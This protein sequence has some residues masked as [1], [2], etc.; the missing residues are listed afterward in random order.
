MNLN[1]PSAWL[2]WFL[3][4]KEMS[5]P[6]GRA[7]FRYRTSKFEFGLLQKILDTN[8]NDAESWNACFV[9]YASEC[10]RRNYTE[11]HWSWDFIVGSLSSSNSVNLESVTHRSKV[12]ESGVKYWKR[13]VYKNANG[14]NGYLS[15]IILECG[16]PEGILTRSS[17]WLTQVIVDAYEEL[18]AISISELEPQEVVRHIAEQKDQFPDSLKKEEIYE[19]VAQITLEAINLKHSY[20]LENKQSPTS[21]LDAED[22]NWRVAFPIEIS[23]VAA[24]FLD[25]LLT[26][27]AKLPEPRKYSISLE[28]ELVQTNLKW[29]VKA[30]LRFPDNFYDYEDL[31][32]TEQELV[33]PVSNVDIELGSAGETKKI[34]TAFKTQKNGKEGFFIK[35]IANFQLGENACLHSWA[36]RLS[37][38]EHDVSI[39]LPLPGGEAL[40][41]DLPWVFEEKG[42]RKLF[43][44]TGSVSSKSD[45]IY[46][47]AEKA[48]VKNGNYQ[49]V[50]S[51]NEKK[52][53]Y[54][55]T[56]DCS[57]TVDDQV[58]LYETSTESDTGYFYTLQG[59]KIDYVSSQ[60]EIVYA[61]MPT[62]YRVDSDNLSKAP[63][64]KGIHVRRSGENR[65]H[66]DGRDKVGVLFIRVLGEKSEVLF[67]KKINVL[68]ANFSVSIE[69]TSPVQGKINLENSSFFAIGI[70]EDELVG[71]IENHQFGHSVWIKSKEEVPP[72]NIVISLG[73]G[74]GNRLTIEVPFPS[75]GAK[76]FDKG[77]N[78]MA[79]GQK[80]YL[81]DLFGYSLSLF[82]AASTWKV[83]NLI[84]SLT[85]KESSGIRI[86]R[87]IKVD[88][89]HREVPLIRYRDEFLK[90]FS[91]TEI[92]DAEVRVRVEH[93]P[94]VTIK[95]YSTSLKL[96]SYEG[97]AT[98]SGSFQNLS[99]TKIS[100]FRFDE[101]LKSQE[102]CMLDLISMDENEGTWSFLEEDRKP[103]KW[104]L[105]PNAESTIQFRPTL[106]IIGY[107]TEEQP[108]ISGI[109]HI[110]EAAGIRNA[111][112][113]IDAL[114]DLAQRMSQDLGNPNWQEVSQLWKL[115]NHLPLNTFD[116]WT[117]FSRNHE[118]LVSLFFFQE[119]ELINRLSNEYPIL[120]E[121]VSVK[122][123]IDGATSRYEH[124]NEQIP[125]H[126]DTLLDG[127]FQY[128]EGRLELTCIAAILRS[129]ILGFEAPDL[130]A[131][132][133]PNF[134][135]HEFN[136]LLNG[137]A[138]FQGLKNRKAEKGWQWPEYLSQE[139]R[140]MTGKLP[141][142]LKTLFPSEFISH[143]VSVILLPVVLAVSTINKELSLRNEGNYAQLFQLRE[144]QSFDEEWFRA[145]Y[146][147]IQGYYWVNHKFIKT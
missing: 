71:E 32:L 108:C 94:S 143:R 29:I 103:G 106:W 80:L 1:T 11:G 113:R 134:I 78:V 110:R 10:W 41:D 107:E 66:Q 127:K 115:T 67:S 18:R 64:T 118:A 76:F 45:T 65:W 7:L 125:E 138:G 21:F 30:T 146:N 44:G 109:T 139:I 87:K 74:G 100:A 69:S 142:E 82:N 121:T 90:L 2:S 119:N 4:R 31:H 20:Q 79:E 48:W 25:Q 40:D 53:I 128:I 98:L 111:S 50:G 19:L 17:H 68:S 136:R 13:S 83:Y 23:E 6:D 61:G 39:K 89:F 34:H 14:H 116:L 95:G 73:S 63:V 58:F 86:F 123:W 117:A 102:I 72:K 120:W 55:V 16:L 9:L 3:N 126:A 137:G 37:N 36:L 35:S 5:A 77:E 91:I 60:G 92:L 49:S 46:V 8:W 131:V 145:I 38:Y 22:P 96:H 24:K 104:L 42:G 130:Q 43:K 132:A 114:V 112:Q 88:Q 140:L 97:T 47:V 84:F 124:L 52:E 57:I 101:S 99:Y 12:I 141:Q 56:S 59:K 133:N 70:K 93:G 33:H 75:Q 105:F 62:I 122:A 27:V 135:K 26:E 54:Q 81:N 144:I 85:G 147:L 28:R 51:F 129:E 15:T